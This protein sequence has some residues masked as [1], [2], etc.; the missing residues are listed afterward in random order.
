M[1]TPINNLNPTP[2][3]YPNIN[4]PKQL[5]RRRNNRID[6]SPT[7][8]KFN[9]IIIYF[10]RMCD[11]GNKKY[12]LFTEI[13]TSACDEGGDTLLELACFLFLVEYAFFVE[14]D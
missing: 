5:I 11:I 1:Y 14:V 12:Y 7:I 3:K 9:K 2:T 13:F 10:W 4:K 8:T 6:T